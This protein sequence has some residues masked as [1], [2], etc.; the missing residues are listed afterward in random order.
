[1]RTYHLFRHNVKIFF[2][3]G[4]IV[5]FALLGFKLTGINYDGDYN[6]TFAPGSK[7]ADAVVAPPNHA[8]IAVSATQLFADYTADETNSDKKYKGKM[9]ELTGVVESINR[10]ERDN[11]YIVM[12]AGDLQIVQCSLSPNFKDKAIV[13]IPGQTV[14]ITGEGAAMIGGTPVMVKCSV[15]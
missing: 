3:L 5:G 11:V 9:M 4:V 14:T 7:D 12:H 6:G 1:M 2:K 10:D 15:K 13:L 8:P